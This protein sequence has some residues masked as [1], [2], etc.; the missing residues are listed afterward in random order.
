MFVNP[1]CII[2]ERDGLR[3]AMVAG[4]PFH[5]WPLGDTM[6]ENLFVVQA[7]QLQVATVQELAVALGRSERSLFLAV[8][9]YA[10]KGG[11]AAL[12]P[13]QLGRPATGG[14]DVLRDAAIRRLHAAGLWNR[15]IA[16]QLKCAPLTV[17]RALAR[18]GLE[19]HRKGRKRPV[20]LFEEPVPAAEAPAPPV[21]PD[22]APPEPPAIASSD[23]EE[24]LVRSF[25]ADPRDRSIDRLRASMGGLADAAPLFADGENLPHVG[26][27][28]AVPGLVQSGLLPEARRLYGD[29]GPAFYGL[30]TALVAIV[31][32]SLL[33]LKRPEHLKEFSPPD[34]GR[35]LGLDR[36]PEVK[37]MRRK[38]HRLAA[39]PCEVLVLAVSQRRAQASDQEALAW[40]YVDGH[41][42][43][44]NGKER[45]PMAHVTRM[46]ISMPAMQD[47]WVHDGDGCPVLCVTQ[48]AHPSLAAALPPLLE[49]AREVVGE[50]RVTI[51]FDRGGWSPDLFKTLVASNADVLTYRKGASEP[52]PASWFEPRSGRPTEPDWLLHEASVRLPNGLWMRQITRLV[53]DHQTV[54]VTTRQDLPAE[55][56]ARRMFDRWCQ[57]NFF[58]YMRQ[59][60]DLDGLCEYGVEVEDPLRETPNPEWTRRDK[61][62][63]K[64]RD[65]H[66]AL[67]ARVLDRNNAAIIEAATQIQRDAGPKAEQVGVV[68][69]PA[70]PPPPL[71]DDLLPWV[72][73]AAER[74]HELRR[75]RD[76]EPRRVCLGDMEKPTVRLPARVKNLYDGLKTVAW[77]IET[78]LFRAVAPYYRRTDEEG[79][80]LI[81]SAL[82]SSGSLRVGKGELVVTL[83]PQSSPHRTRAIAALCR[84]L[85]NTNTCFPGTD[86]RLRYRIEGIDGVPDAP[87]TAMSAG[88]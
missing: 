27:L 20:R 26:V 74:M 53:G 64:A 2:H 77:Q 10:E 33:R 76:V 1:L 11:A 60:F 85:D 79:R 40:L 52:V 75:Q 41:V 35:V 50:R 9:I 38:L 18:M 65:A 61:A 5:T 81:T 72:A 28:L 39:G 17:D 80:T 49:A 54:I 86:L 7:R 29:I 37:T 43:V 42:R 15:P 36:A 14:T 24:P 34:L 66:R 68:E 58:K 69:K 44:Y 82:R 22:P 70:I 30:R 59:E 31:L 16:E 21:V 87:S 47:M 73:A 83:A 8:K 12:G 55:V 78:D 48:E 84:L 71:D 3:V 6:A 32:L 67:L 88:G 62:F 13:K 4:T 46:R 25:D 57:E 45:L 56:L 19:P 23:E 51:V 63:R